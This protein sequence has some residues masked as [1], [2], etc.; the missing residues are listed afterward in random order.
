MF[1]HFHLSNLIM[2]YLLGVMITAASCGRGPAILSS[3][4]SVMGFDF[5]FVPPGSHSPWKRPSISLPSSS[6]FWWPWLSVTW[7][8]AYGNRSRLPGTR[9]GRQPPCMVSV[10]SSPAPEE[11]RNI[12]QVAVQYIS[13]IFD[14][15]CMVMVPND[16]GKLKVIAGDPSSVFTRMS[17]KKF[18][19]AHA[20]LRQRTN[21]RLG[22][23]VISET[24]KISMCLFERPISLWESWSCGPLIR[25]ASG[26]R[27]N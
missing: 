13:E 14:G 16:Q 19:I 2:I 8:T 6:C 25:T 15:Q 22:H 26:T 11:R 5:F 4:L 7:L 20:G 12:F 17:S 21:N 1:P 10:A 9:S 18:K 27:S 23:T 24:A 3:F